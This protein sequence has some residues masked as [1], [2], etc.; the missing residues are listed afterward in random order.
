MILTSA[1]RTASRAYQRDLLVNTVES[2]EEVVREWTAFLQWTG[3]NMGYPVWQRQWSSAIYE[4]L[5]GTVREESGATIALNEVWY[6]VMN[7]LM[8]RSASLNLG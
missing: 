2:G 4:S 6:A 7:N 3:Q 8:I 1:T 5:K